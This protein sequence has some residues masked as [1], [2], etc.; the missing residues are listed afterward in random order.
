MDILVG[1]LASVSIS[2]QIS[3]LSR[4]WGKLR[5][6]WNMILPMVVFLIRF[7][8]GDLRQ[9]LFWVDILEGICIDGCGVGGQLGQK[10]DI[11]EVPILLRRPTTGIDTSAL[12]R[13]T[14][15]PQMLDSAPAQA[16][17]W[18]NKKDARR[19]FQLLPPPI[20]HPYFSANVKYHCYI[21]FIN[22]CDKIAAYLYLAKHI[23]FIMI[24]IHQKYP[25]LCLGCFPGWSVQS[26]YNA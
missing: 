18:G 9:Y 17:E 16:P 12:V 3:V 8:D 23:S 24:L 7:F 14:D 2:W 11:M 13:Q 6:S 15:T 5:Q 22:I 10:W 25:H 19:G 21:V 4:L 20:T 1:I 26:Q